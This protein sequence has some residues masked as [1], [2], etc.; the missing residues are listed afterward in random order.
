MSD[1]LKDPVVEQVIDRFRWRSQ[2][3]QQKYGQKMTRTDLRLI[4]WM[5]HAEEE[6]MDQLLYLRRAILDLEL[7]EDDGK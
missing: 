5:R 7:M 2:L 6:L 3:G 4:D 1:D